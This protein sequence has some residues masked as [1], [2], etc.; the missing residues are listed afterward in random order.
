MYDLS[1]KTLSEIVTDHYETARVFEKYNLDFCCKGNRSLLSA[2]EEKNLPIEAILEDLSQVLSFDEH[3]K[4][5]DQ[6]TLTEISAYIVRVHHTYVKLNSP[7]LLNYLLKVATKHGERFPYMKKVYLLF[8]EL[9]E[10][11]MEHMAKEETVLFPQIALL[12]SDPGQMTTSPLLDEPIDVMK[13][14]H[15]RAGNLISEI[16]KLT[17]DFEA[18]EQACTT[19]R[20]SL[21]SLKAFEEDLHKHVHLENNILFPKAVDSFPGTKSC[22]VV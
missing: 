13:L 17:N 15:D 19:F 9:L 7:L 5:F 16:R 22:C 20:L 14:E 6:M 10:E 8:A 3:G 21:D 4:A 1:S 12:E 2:C 11:L 18:P